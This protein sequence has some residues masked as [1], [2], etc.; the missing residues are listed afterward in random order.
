MPLKEPILAICRDI[1]SAGGRALL[2]GGYVRD[3]LLGIDN[4]DLDFEIY[5]LTIQDLEAALQKHGE[6][7]SVG[8][9][10][11]VLRLKGFDVD[12]ALP[13]IDK[14][15]SAGHKGFDVRVDLTLDYAEASRRRDLTI[16]SMGLDPLTGEIL[17]PHGGCKDLDA[18]ILRA[19]DPRYFGEDPLRA[20]RV[21][22]FAARFAMRPD[23][24]L[25]GLCAALDLSELSAERIFG[26]IEKLLIKAARPSIGLTFLRE[27]RLLRFF[28][29]LMHLVGV[30]QDPGWHPEGDVWTHTL[31]VVDRAATMRD[32]GP[33][34]LTLMLAA[35]CHD[36]GKATT[37]T[38]DAA[39]IRSYSHEAEG[40]VLARGFLERLK[41][42]QALTNAVCILVEHHLA[43]TQL[44]DQQ[45]SD[46]AFRRLARKLTEAGATLRLLERLCRADHLGRTTPEASKEL[47]PEGDEFLRRIESLRVADAAPGDIV[48]GRHV[49]AR[50]I[51]PG[52]AVGEILRRCREV[53][54]E[55]GWTEPDKILDAVLP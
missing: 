45:A 26:E 19:T 13:R 12:F 39:H 44:V 16:N 40:A 49:L 29:E 35:L 18:R 48:L 46:K 31:M 50:G 3:Q 6:V 23:P 1:A 20:L 22:Q 36:F 10:F 14:K 25:V 5:G 51:A 24:D 2:V 7:L 52:P 11:G 54:D 15:V 43:P 33:T 30:S 17:D 32:G 47:Y 55:T 42:P 38:V 8:R 34:D 37:T 41:A 27:A 4:K 53:Q 9:Q 21:A 28:P